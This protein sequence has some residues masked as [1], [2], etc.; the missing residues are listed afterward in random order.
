MKSLLIITTKLDAGGA[1]RSLINFL[2]SYDRSRY[3]VDL[4]LLK[5]EGAFLKYVPEDVRI[6]EQDKVLFYMYNMAKF[7]LGT[8]SDGLHRD[9][10][11]GIPFVVRRV[12][13]T[14]YY[15][16]VKKLDRPTAEQYRW[17][18]SYSKVIEELT[19]HYDCAM[20][21]LEG[22]PIYYLV[23]KVSADRKIGW[24]HNDY[25]KIA[26]D[27]DFDEKYFAGLDNIVTISD[28][29]VDVLKKNF[30]MLA[31]KVVELPNI[32]SAEV[33]EK[34][35]REFVPE[36]YAGC[37]SDNEATGPSNAKR[38]VLLSIGRLTAQKAFDRIIPIA[39]ALK[40]KGVSFNWFVLGDGELRQELV[41]KVSEAGLQDSVK[42]LGIRSNPYP[43]IKGA[44][45]IVQT[46]L[47][48][49]KSVVI[50]EAKILHK[51]IVATNYDTIM[52]Q[53]GDYPIK[54][55]EYEPEAVA[56]RIKEVINED[57]TIDA[58][59][60]YGNVECLEEYYRV[61]G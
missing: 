31:E 46:S 38:Y 6:L 35:A 26:G 34:F 9:F 24:I 52:D 58:S 4:L 47:F 30:P 15:K 42:F 41:S 1:E 25:E 57:M 39:K 19:G 37:G 59:K 45:V 48:E 56:E 49:G 12:W 7:S 61:I 2:N 29:C 53:V 28:K 10:L 11:H 55:V 60:N 33:I 22:E 8:A 43:Y 20:A 21:Y 16:K 18:N 5:R 32:N 14:I 36:E 50:D 13:S 40:D 44:D 17:E 27:R 51:K 54:V 23:D 3:T